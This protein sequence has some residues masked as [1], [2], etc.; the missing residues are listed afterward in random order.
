MGGDLV[1]E[2]EA[3]RRD[4]G[5]EEQTIRKLDD[6]L[7]VD[8]SLLVH[9]SSVNLKHEPKATS[10][11]EGSE[12]KKEAK[13][14][15]GSRVE[16]ETRASFVPSPRLNGDER[17]EAL[18]FRISILPCSLGKGISIFLSKRPG[19]SSAG[20]SVSGRLVAMINFVF[21]SESNPSIWLRSCGKTRASEERQ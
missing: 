15:G 2:K 1:E 8:L 21:P 11:A 12:W 3:E 14:S 13:E 20:S 9:W 16:N 10:V 17:K 19:L 4:R 6:S 18:T 5:R 7:H